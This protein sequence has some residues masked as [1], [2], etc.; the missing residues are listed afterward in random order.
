MT[1]DVRYKYIRYIQAMKSRRI[2]MVW[3]WVTRAGK[4]NIWKGLYVDGRIIL[5]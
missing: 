2:E 1:T 4:D 5:W 3:R